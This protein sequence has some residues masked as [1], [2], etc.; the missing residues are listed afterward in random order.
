[1]ALH[2]ANRPTN[3]AGNRVRRFYIGNPKEINEQECFNQG[4][5]H[6]AEGG[7]DLFEVHWHRFED[8]CPQQKLLQ[9]RNPDKCYIIETLETEGGLT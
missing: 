8:G 2:R 4:L 9:Y 7:S 6:M 5:R 1:M 3:H